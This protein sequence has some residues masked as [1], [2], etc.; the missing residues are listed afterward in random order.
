MNRCINILNGIYRER[1][2]SWLP[3]G[4]IA[5]TSLSGGHTKNV[6][7]QSL[8]QNKVWD[9]IFFEVEPLSWTL[10]FLDLDENHHVLDML[11]SR[12]LAVSGVGWSRGRIEVPKSTFG[13]LLLYSPNCSIISRDKI[14]VGLYLS[15]SYA[16]KFWLSQ[17]WRFLERRS[18]L[19][20][21]GRMEITRLKCLAIATQSVC[22]NLRS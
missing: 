19:R 21:Q 8:L 1:L 4:V 5:G 7:H 18:L 11:L 6:P 22:S 2:D 20:L 12:I 3:I 14:S 9:W 13:A 17:R 16:S 15:H 10:Q